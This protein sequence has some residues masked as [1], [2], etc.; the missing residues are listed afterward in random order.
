MMALPQRKT[1]QKNQLNYTATGGKKFRSLQIV[2]HLPSIHPSIPV[3]SSPHMNV[4]FFLF[5]LT[6]G[7]RRDTQGE[8]MQTQGERA[9]HT[10]RRARLNSM[11]LHRFLQKN[12]TAV[13]SMNQLRRT[14]IRPL[15]DSQ[16]RS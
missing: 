1:S 8:C 10:Q 6:V 3:F 14:K 2:T 9:N 11:Y 4:F 7:G 5:F 13:C 12:P 15:Q 16:S